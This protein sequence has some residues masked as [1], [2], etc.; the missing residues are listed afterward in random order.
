[1]ARE[2]NKLSALA[3]K[4][5]AT[6]GRH[7]D[8]GGLYL[9]VDRGGAKRWA[10]IY[11]DRHTKKL[12]E[13]GLG[14]LR[15]VTLARAREKA[16]AARAT[17]AAGK[18]PLTEKVEVDGAKVP[19]F[20][21]VADQLIESLEPSW[22]NAKHAAQWRS[23]LKIHCEPIRELPVDAVTSEL[24]LRVLQP[25][26]QRIPETAGRVRGRIEM[27]LDAA[28]AKGHRQGENPARWR[29]HLDKLLPARRKLVRGHQP[30][31]PFE[32]VSA[33]VGDLRKREAIAARALEWVILTAARTGEAIGA[34]WSEIDRER[35]VWTIPGFDLQTGR[36]MKGGRQH[37]VP[38]S[39][40]CMEILAEME[41]FGTTG[42][43][44]PGQNPDEPLSDMA[45]L[46]LL[47]RMG[48]RHATVHGFRS[49]FRDWC[50]ECTNFPRDVAELA[51]A[52]VVGDQTEAAYRRAT[53]LEKRRKLMEAWA[54]YCEPKVVPLRAVG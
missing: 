7:G 5:L 47:R 1:M 6:P 43:V 38:L 8:G 34:L 41:K 40:R 35:G 10:F 49:T 16:A 13:M 31:M 4:A 32:H 33:F 17:L 25:I 3:V 18:D 45:L 27:V 52:H 20:G 26:W 36:R 19:T 22:R 9:V 23:T 30:A 50:G 48:M 51:L 21:E 46:M 2:I 11:R 14:G 42:L 54:A 24:V 53:A 12:R 15:S 37:Q 39:P 28:K 44:F 29:G